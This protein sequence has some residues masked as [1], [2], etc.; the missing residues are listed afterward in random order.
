MKSK[1][2]NDWA[3]LRLFLPKGWSSKAKEMGVFSRRRQFKSVGIL[4]RTLLIHLLEGCS[5]KETAVRA[6][7][8]GICNVTSVAIFKRL[9]KSGEWFNWMALRLAE[10]KGI[11]IKSPVWIS[12]YDVK[13]VDASVICEPGS[14]GTD[15]RLHYSM[16]LFSLRADQFQLTGPEVGESLKHFKIQAGELWLADRAYCHYSQLNYVVKNKADFIVRWKAK[17]ASLFSDDKPFNLLEKVKSLKVGQIG[18]W[19]IEAKLSSSKEA[20]LVLRICAVAKTKQKAEEAIRA[21]KKQAL[22]KG[23]NYSL[24]TLELQKY[25]I[26]ITSLPSS[27]DAFKVMKLYRARWQEEVAFKRMKSL[28]KIGQLPKKDPRSCLAW[29]QGK[30]FISLLVQAVHDEARLFSP[31]GYPLPGR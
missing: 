29:L 5:L 16:T 30:L 14:T 7:Q 28:I 17:G 2:Y 21:Y 13:T 25:I 12:K 26:V 6:E 9:Q 8:G 4:L 3:D 23:R 22:K 19:P 20:G 10:N 24:T 1:I 18:D 15:W 11:R 31:W 27:I